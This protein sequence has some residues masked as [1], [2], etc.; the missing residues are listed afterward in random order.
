MDRALVFVTLIL[1]TKEIDIVVSLAMFTFQHMV[2]F[3]YA[4]VMF[5]LLKEN[6]SG[7]CL[8]VQREIKWGEDTANY[9]RR[10]EGVMACA[11]GCGDINSSF[12]CHSSG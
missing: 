11:E 8:Q 3:N 10:A 7:T 2:N 4:N 9:I 12:Y 6:G 1:S 5:V